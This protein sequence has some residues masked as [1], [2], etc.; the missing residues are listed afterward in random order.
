[1]TTVPRTNW[2]A[3]MRTTADR[4]AATSIQTGTESVSFT[5]A[6]SF[7]QDV[8]FPV[9]YATAPTVV[10]NINSG[11]GATSRWDTRAIGITATGFQLFGY[12]TQT[13][14]AAATWSAVP[15]GWVANG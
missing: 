3:G 7:T 6:T 12:T 13:D 2:L 15:V 10:T 1:M 11:A 8:T 5:S 4:L 14:A 9:A